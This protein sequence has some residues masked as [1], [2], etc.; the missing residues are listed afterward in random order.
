M[1]VMKGLTAAVEDEGNAAAA[2]AAAAEVDGGDVAAGMSRAL[3]AVSA[4]YAEF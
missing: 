3:A 1:C 4:A 2:A